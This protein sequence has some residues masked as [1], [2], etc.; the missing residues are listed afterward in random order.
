MWFSDFLFSAADVVQPE[1]L[2]PSGKGNLSALKGGATLKS[3]R[4]WRKQDN[5]QYKA[6]QDRLNSSRKHRPEDHSANGCEVDFV[7]S[8][9]EESSSTRKIV[10]AKE[11]NILIP[12]SFLIS[13]CVYS[14]MI[15]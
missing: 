9:V 4:G 3:R 5:Q 7:E 13:Y 6:R 15:M 10:Q 12:M 2:C 11:V 14:H 1:P 8:N